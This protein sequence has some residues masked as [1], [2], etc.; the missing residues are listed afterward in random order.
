[1]SL[2]R[3]LCGLVLTNVAGCR[4]LH[5]R[6]VRRPFPVVPDR[7]TF[8]RAETTKPPRLLI[9]SFKALNQINSS[10]MRE[11]SIEFSDQFLSKWKWL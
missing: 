9:R 10:Y 4:G 2:G 3:N 5:Q 11:V 7:R 1:M 6:R 8:S